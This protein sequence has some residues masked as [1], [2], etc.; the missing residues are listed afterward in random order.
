MQLR[1]DRQLGDWYLFAAGTKSEFKRN[2]LTGSASSSA[3]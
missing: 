3:V 2:T 1:M